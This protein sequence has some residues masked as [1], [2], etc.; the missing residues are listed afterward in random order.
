M[1]EQLN[2]YN[3]LRKLLLLETQ[4][5]ELY[6]RSPFKIF[7]IKFTTI[8]DGLSESTLGPAG[9][10]LELIIQNDQWEQGG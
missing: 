6:S 8:I 1:S 7:F 5:S 9:P 4:F 3:S 10:V 2:S